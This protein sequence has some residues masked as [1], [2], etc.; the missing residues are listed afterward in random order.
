MRRIEIRSGA[1]QRRIASLL[2]A[3]QSCQTA[4][5]QVF[6]ALSAAR[7]C[8]AAALIARAMYKYRLNFGLRVSARVERSCAPGCREGV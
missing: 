3:I 5:Q 6:I 4:Q 7:L 2:V 8:A 1:E